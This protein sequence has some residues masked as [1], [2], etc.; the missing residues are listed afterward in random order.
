MMKSTKPSQ[1]Q[2][3]FTV[4]VYFIVHNRLCAAYRRTWQ[5]RLA[6]DSDFKE[7]HC[8]SSGAGN[9]NGQHEGDESSCRMLL[10]AEEEGDT[11]QW[12][13]TPEDHLVSSLPLLEDGKF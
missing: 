12:E 1:V 7:Y 6:S 9:G 8:G 5:S 2:G 3:L 11:V 10:L 13:L 4:L